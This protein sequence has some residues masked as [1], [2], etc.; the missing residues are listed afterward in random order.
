MPAPLTNLQHRFEP[1]TFITQQG[2]RVFDP[3]HL[4]P[5]IIPARRGVDALLAA[6]SLLGDAAADVVFAKGA[7]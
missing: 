4:E 2:E 7:R 6:G 3:R 1:A 5:Q